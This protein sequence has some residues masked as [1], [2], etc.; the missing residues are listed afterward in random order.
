MAKQMRIPDGNAFKLRIA[1]QIKTGEYVETAD[2]SVVR[3][4]IVNFV[5][6]GRE[7]QTSSV[8]GAGRIVVENDGS[9]ARG[10]YGVELT[11]YYNGEPWRF[12]VKDV[13]QIVNENAESD[14]PT[15]VD[16]VPVY[17]V[18]VDVSFGGDGI[19]AAF[20]EAA[21]NMH[22]S[23]ENSHPH[24]L[25]ELSGKVDDVEVDG[26]SVVET[27]PVT[28]KRI[29]GFRKDQFGKVDDV[30]VNGESVLNAANE[31]NI[32]V[33]TTVEELSDS[34]DFAKKTDLQTMQ[35][36][37]AQAISDT[38]EQ[39]EQS[40]DDATVSEVEATVD[41]NTG[42]PEVDYTFENGK[43]QLD[44]KNLKGDKGDKLQFSD[45]TEE[46][47]ASL[48]GAQGDSVI[49]GEGDLPMAHV[50]GK[51]NTK[52]MSQGGVNA[53]LNEG[54]ISN[55]E[56]TETQAVA[57]HTE[58][59]D[60][61]LIVDPSTG[62]FV[63]GYPA[64]RSIELDL[65]QDMKSITYN[66]SAYNGS[67][68]GGYAF[69]K[70]DG[71]FV[72]GVRTTTAGNVTIDVATPLSEGATKFR[73]CKNVSASTISVTIKKETFS[74]PQI[75]DELGNNINGWMTQKAVKQAI[76]GS[77]DEIEGSLDEGKVGI[78]SYESIEQQ[79]YTN[80]TDNGFYVNGNTGAFSE[81]P[82]HRSIELPLTP[83]IKTISYVASAYTKSY[84]PGGYAFV[85]D[86]GTYVSGVNTQTDGKITIDAEEAISLGA[87]KFRCSI[88]TQVGSFILLT[89]KK[90][91]M[92]WPQRYTELGHNEDGWATQ[93]AVS[94][95]LEGG[96]V[97]TNVETQTE[98]VAAYNVS[99]NYG[100]MVNGRTGE[101]MAGAAHRAI[102]IPLTED[103]ISISYMASAYNNASYPGGYAFL[104]EFDNYISGEHT[105]ATATKVVD[106]TAP[107]KSG[108]RK[109]RCSRNDNSVN[110]IE[111]TIKTGDK[112]WPKK[113]D[114]TGMNEDGWMTQ[115]AVTQA[116]T[117]GE[118][119]IL[120][121]GNSLLQDSVAYLPTL[122]KSLA[123]KL[124]FKIYDW[125]SGGY[126][127]T[128]S[129]NAFVNDTPCHIF[130]KNENGDAW[131]NYENSVTMDT[132]LDTYDFDIIVLQEMMREGSTVDTTG[133]KNVISYI[134]ERYA[135]PLN[136]AC[137][138]QAPVRHLVS[139]LFPMIVAQAKAM[140]EETEVSS[141]INVGGAIVEAMKTELDSLGAVTHLSADG[142][143]AQEGLP[144]LVQSYVHAMWIFRQ[145]G[146]PYG[147]VGDKLRITQEIYDAI[148]VP[149]PNLG[150]GD[151]AGVI[152]GTD[153]Q[154]Y[155]AQLCAIK[156][157]K[158]AQAYERQAQD[159]MLT[160]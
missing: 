120:Y 131:T 54:K 75:Y 109:F 78:I 34:S 147:I 91:T 17:D 67:Y 133:T 2:F 157:D 62:A 18:T 121:I 104:D 110:Y 111:L 26:E 144:C 114:E 126:T 46:E 11:G 89:V 21:V 94:D 61:G 135:K 47:K 45:L 151:G 55:G 84:A 16:N 155:I 127:L 129:Y 123:P 22:N 82:A 66:A 112:A 8:D 32:V 149:G 100:W 97:R 51:D 125:Y 159:E 148:H 128:Q 77:L 85:K 140:Y 3:N 134:R 102:E 101:Y 107:F 105:T 72:S 146:L 116:I 73:C 156:A 150:T 108:A 81:G 25:G 74:W 96:M 40:I 59:G 99:G 41:N 42:T 38:V 4:M 52:A 90:E 9:L 137:I 69:V 43:I 92:S 36:Q 132:I 93:K 33:P 50:L 60:N 76:E 103:M 70:S 63:S 138:T 117:D 65:T 5:R 88:Q 153:A 30:K 142:L 71:T 10:V 124:R 122:L 79:Y 49:V 64:H 29:V 13:F 53:A 136:V 20:V 98:Q 44:F 160:S 145:L 12:Y 139:T 115:K 24:I 19:S 158:A 80:G 7:A 37:V 95:N 57:V 106:V 48:K 154:H 56:T 86:D 23:D 119:K 143:H 39:L 27:D 83:E 15:G 6:R 87:T 118:V 1:G 14:E 113:Y 68:A 28:G 141:I 58:G 31:A 35:G 130:S 152:T